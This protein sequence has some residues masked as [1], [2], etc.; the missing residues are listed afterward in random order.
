MGCLIS[1]N[2]I[3]ARFI[4][5][6]LVLIVLSPVVEN[7]RKKPRDEFPLSYFPMF[8]E[9]RRPE[10]KVTYLVGLDGAGNRHKIPYK[11]AGNGGLNQVRKQIAAKV[12]LGEAEDLCG[13]VAQN[14][15]KRKSKSYADLTEVRIVTESIRWTATSP[16]TSRRKTKSSKP[17]ASFCG[18]KL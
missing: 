15:A 6:L 10:M 14:L 1:Y 4:S 7:W 8:S 9:K 2:R 16:A 5:V 17:V 13:K 12:R 18:S 11:F 3:A